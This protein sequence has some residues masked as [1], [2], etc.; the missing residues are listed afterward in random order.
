MNLRSML[1]IQI[2]SLLA[3]DEYGGWI[4]R[5][6]GLGLGMR[7]RFHILLL[8][9]WRLRE[10]LSIDRVDEGCGNPEDLVATMSTAD[11]IA[12]MESYGWLYSTMKHLEVEPTKTEVPVI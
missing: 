4:D 5:V 7:Y 9:D 12:K 11:G 1:D 3:S 8:Q 6:L 2:P 10:M